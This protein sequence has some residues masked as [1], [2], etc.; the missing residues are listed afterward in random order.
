MCIEINVIIDLVRVL[1]VP[2][3]FMILRTALKVAPKLPF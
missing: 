2:N 3:I 1:S